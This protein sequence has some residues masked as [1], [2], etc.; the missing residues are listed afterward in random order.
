MSCSEDRSK[1]S[2]SHSPIQ[3]MKVVYMRNK[4][5]SIN[6]IVKNRQDLH[7]MQSRSN[8]PLNSLQQVEAAVRN[9]VTK[10]ERFA[11]QQQRSK[12]S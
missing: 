1:D 2:L 9:I 10:N 11:W 6:Y 8:S 12:S 3:P 7:R 4:T 5:P